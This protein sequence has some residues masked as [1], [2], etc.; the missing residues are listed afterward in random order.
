[1]P[2]ELTNVDITHISYVDK[3]ANQK[4]FFLT[5]SAKKP[6]FQKQVR[7]I[8]KADDAKKLVYGVVYEPEAE[9]TH[10]DMMTAEEIEKAVHGF[11]SNLAIAKGAV[12]DTQHDFDPGV[13][14]VVECYIAPVD[15]ELGGETIRKGSWVLVTKASDDIW[16]QIQS[17]DITGYSMAGTA[18]AIEKQNQEPAAK[19][20]DEA[21]GFFRTMKAFFTGSNSNEKIA[22]GAVADK[23]ERDRRRRE[24]WAAQDALNSVIFNWDY[25]DS[26]MERD[27]ETIR[28]AL[29]DF[30]TIAQE[31][32]IQEDI[33]KAIGKPPEAIGKAGKKIS[34]G[35]LKHVDDAIAALTELKNKT[36]PAD[37]GQEEEDDLKPEDI[38]KA[39]QAAVAPIAKQ[40]TDLTNE[41]TELKKQEGEGT[42]DVGTATEPQADALTDAIAKALEPLTQQ[43]N[44]LAADVLIVKNS[45]GGSRQGGEQEEIHKASG[46]STLSRFV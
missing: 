4:R 14:D 2:R 38:A 7:L 5:K 8:T 25:W 46:A 39:V 33:A 23:Y 45:R 13:G 21:M 16:E 37:E 27:P 36:A 44:T 28:E 31:V 20:D 6:D 9:D 18:E 19:S 41:I 32:L 43:M 34:A 10:G 24:F 42:P 40:V 11:M 29:Q 12:M 35:N 26:E 3:G 1:M 15:F 30:I 22:K 17:G